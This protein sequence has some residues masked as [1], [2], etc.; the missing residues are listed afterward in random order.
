MGSSHTEKFNYCL[1]GSNGIYVGCSGTDLQLFSGSTQSYLRANSSWGPSGNDLGYGINIS[2]SGW[3]NGLYQITGV[4]GSAGTVFYWIVDRNPG[5]GGSLT[6]GS[7]FIG[8]TNASPGNAAGNMVGGNTLH[9]QSGSVYMCSDTQNVSGGCISLPAGVTSP[10]NRQTLLCGYSSALYDLC[11]TYSGYPKLQKS[12]GTT[13]NL[14]A[15]A[16]GSNVFCVDCDA[17]NLAFTCVKGGSVNQSLLRWAIVRNAGNSSVFIQNC[18]AKFV[19]IYAGAVGSSRTGFWSTNA[20]FC[21]AYGLNATNDAAFSQQGG[22]TAI[23]CTAVNCTEG[24]VGQDCINCFA[25]SCPTGFA[26]NDS[27]NY[28]VT[29]LINCFAHSCATKAFALQS[30]GASSSTN[31]RSLL[32]NCGSYNSGG[33]DSTLTQVNYIGC[34]VDPCNNAGAGDFRWN[35]LAG[36][37]QLLRNAG[38][39]SIPGVSGSGYPDI[40]PFQTLPAFSINAWTS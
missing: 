14:I 32:L 18:L 27:G 1:S 15:F 30:P 31:Y 37:G 24:F 26:L 17:N 36:G 25:Y 9:L 40:G 33:A 22:G 20:S 5:Y 6:S 4:S 21:Y 23:N 16:V 7:Y 28:S 34:T 11:G 39:A 2:G 35:N 10:A 12:A 8:G 38:F 13:N 3:Q 29:A 19:Q